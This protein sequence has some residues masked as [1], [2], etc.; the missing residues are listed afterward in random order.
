MTDRVR[1]AALLRERADGLLVEGWIEG[2]CAEGADL[3][4]INGLMEDFYEDPGFVR[5][6]FEFATA[7]ELDFARAQVD[8]GV[9]IV[10]IGD[11]A[12]SLV[13]PKLYEEF[14]WPCEKR[15]VDGVH[16]MGALVRLHICGNTR[17]LLALMG[18]LGADLVDLD[19]YSPL[20]EARAL[21]GPRQVLLGNLDPVRTLRDGT[22]LSVTAAIAECHRQAGARYVVGAGCEVARGTPPENVMAL[23][24]YARGSRG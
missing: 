14:V 23:R 8:A 17:P 15:M 18:R 1:A 9:D 19:Y 20:G 21:M 5:D 10:G 22:P 6:L 7:M 12:A 24:D 16:A 4:G 3:R 11:A 2:P 13:G